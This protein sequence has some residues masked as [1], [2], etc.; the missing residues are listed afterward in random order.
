MSHARLQ[1]I[2]LGRGS[3]RPGLGLAEVSAGGGGAP[4]GGSAARRRQE[5]SREARQGRGRGEA[6]LHHPEE[7][8]VA[9]TQVGVVGVLQGIPEGL[10]LLSQWSVL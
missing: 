6:M 2:P 5:Q 3:E 7:S 8:M 10:R 1:G 9:R 4:A